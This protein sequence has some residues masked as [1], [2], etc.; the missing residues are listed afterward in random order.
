MPANN[1]HDFHPGRINLCGMESY[2]KM[3]F[4]LNLVATRRGMFKMN[5]QIVNTRTPSSVQNICV[6]SSDDTVTSLH[7]A[8]DHTGDV[9][10][11]GTMK[12]K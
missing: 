6:F 11:I 1:I 7:V 12:W 5:F 10:H 3:K 2:Q 9:T 4:E 8:L